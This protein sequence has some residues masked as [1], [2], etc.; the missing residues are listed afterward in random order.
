[1]ELKNG[2]ETQDTRLDRCVQFD[3]RSRNFKISEIVE[4]TLRSY[5]WRCNTW[6]DQGSEGACVGFGV[7]HELAAYAAEVPNLTNKFARERIYWEAQKID[8]WAGGAYPGAS[9]FYEG[10]SVLAGVKIAQKLGYFESYRWA[11]GLED[12]IY[13]VG[14]NGPAVLGIAWTYDMYFPNAYNYIKPT[15]QVV[16]GH[17]ILCRAVNVKNKTFTLRNSW[18]YNWGFKG[19]AYITFA[20]ME[21]L[22][23]MDGEAVFFI[24]RHKVPQ[25]K[26]TQTS[27]NIESMGGVKVSMG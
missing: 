14:H 23:Y 19:D 22:L 21:K 20:D 8:P 17:C 9:P 7:S 26:T 15:G 3:P 6:L 16:G 5:T 4:R 13:G 12:L 11:F 27:E 25:P 1:M 24:D 18:G 10:T 2:V